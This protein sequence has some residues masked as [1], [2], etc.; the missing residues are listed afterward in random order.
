VAKIGTIELRRYEIGCVSGGY[1]VKSRR[2]AHLTR[3]LALLL[4]HPAIRAGDAS[5]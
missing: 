4:L 2:F 1:P 3:P 5:P